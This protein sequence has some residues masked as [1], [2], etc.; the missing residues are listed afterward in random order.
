MHFYCT[1]FESGIVIYTAI[2]VSKHD[3]VSKTYRRQMDAGG[4][5]SSK[6]ERETSVIVEYSVLLQQQTAIRR[7]CAADHR[8]HTR[9]ATNT[10]P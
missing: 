4:G 5:G 6:N 1:H 7:K 3:A 9:A 8:D 10:A 2:K